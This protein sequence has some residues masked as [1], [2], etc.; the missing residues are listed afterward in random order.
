[1]RRWC[2]GTSERHERGR[3]RHQITDHS[4]DL[5]RETFLLTVSGNGQ[6]DGVSVKGRCSRIGGTTG[7]SPRLEEGVDSS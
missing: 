6:D 5:S 1:M 3:S 7:G 2:V 4:V